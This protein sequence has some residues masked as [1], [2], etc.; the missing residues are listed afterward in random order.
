MKDFVELVCEARSCRRFVED[1]PI[2]PDML[3]TLVN[4]VRRT[5]SARNRQPLRYMTVSDVATRL[6]LF[7]HTHW[8][9]VLGWDGPPPG[10]RPTGFIVILSTS[11]ASM[12]VYYDTGIA[13]QTMQLHAV[14]M[15]LGCCMLNNFPRDPVRELLAIPVDMEIMLLLAFGIPKEKRVLLEARAKDDLQ[16]WRD[17]SGVHYVP[18][19]ALEDVLVG[20]R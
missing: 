16:Y 3:R 1:E 11:P 5:T 12:P 19:L 18:K 13:A 6:Q 20:E 4:C 2:G 9:S 8:A 14:S 15:G 10:E 7:T 17:E